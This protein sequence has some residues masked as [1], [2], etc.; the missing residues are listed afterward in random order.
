MG[1][2]LVTECRLHEG[3]CVGEGGG[4]EREGKG[5]GEEQQEI[6]NNKLH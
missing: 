3:R 6:K 5:D 1:K 4:S 2:E